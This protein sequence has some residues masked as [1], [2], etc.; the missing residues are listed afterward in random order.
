MP[1]GEAEFH[2]YFLSAKGRV[3]WF[4]QRSVTSGSLDLFDL[5]KDLADETARRADYSGSEM[6]C[7]GRY[8]A[9]LICTA[10]RTSTMHTGFACER[11][12]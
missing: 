8:T 3:R 9:Q 11:Y 6:L 1:A 10:G 12:H 4:R 5:I 2:R 7:I